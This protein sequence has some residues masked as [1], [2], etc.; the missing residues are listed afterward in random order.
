VRVVERDA[1]TLAKGLQPVAPLD[2][3]EQ[4]EGIERAGDAVRPVADPGAREGMLQQREVEAGV[5]GDEDGAL[6]EPDQ[7]AATSRRRAPSATDAS[8]I[9]CTAVASDGIGPAGRTRLAKRSSSTPSA[10]SRTTASE[11]ISSDSTS[12]PVVSRST[13]AYPRGT[14]TSYRRRTDPGKPPWPGTT[15]STLSERA[16]GRGCRERRTRAT[17]KRPAC[18]EIGCAADSAYELSEASSTNR[19][20]A[21]TSRV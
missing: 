15:R 11:T 6:E 17:Q 1:V 21:L 13:T 12:V 5:V 18:R 7:L 9:P 2:G 10:S 3:L 8:S 4:A 16:I 14:A 20:T 19:H